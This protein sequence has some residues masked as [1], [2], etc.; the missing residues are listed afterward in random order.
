MKKQT[1]KQIKSAPQKENEC[2]RRMLTLATSLLLESK[3]A[4]D[5]DNDRHLPFERASGRKPLKANTTRQQ[6]KI[7]SV[8][9]TE[10]VRYNG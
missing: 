2:K 6:A 3:H 1:H 10:F 4:A 8:E 5:N 9:L 7:L